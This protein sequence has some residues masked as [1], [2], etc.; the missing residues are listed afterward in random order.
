MQSE[1][2]VWQAIEQIKDAYS[3]LEG[4]MLES[5]SIYTQTFDESLSYPF[6][7]INSHIANLILPTFVSRETIP[8]EYIDNGKQILLFSGGKISTAIA[9]MY[10][11]KEENVLLWYFDNGYAD[12]NKIKPNRDNAIK[13]A[14]LLGMDIVISK[15]YY[16]TS[17]P[18][19]MM[20][21]IAEALEFI[22]EERMSPKIITG[23]FYGASVNNNPFELLG[24]SR[25]FIASE[26]DFFRKFIPEFDVSMPI[27]SYSIAWDELM[28]RREVLPYII[29]EDEVDRLTSYIIYADFDIIDSDKDKY[30]KYFNR[31][32]NIYNQETGVKHSDEEVWKRYFFYN[33]SYYSKYF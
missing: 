10:K 31:L 6:H 28:R 11:R 25:E 8:F 4:F 24:Y 9:S 12:P 32:K 19:F 20:K 14:K 3:Y 18:L 30:L 1:I 5:E 21:L 15:S 33:M 23:L 2:D 26:I 13:I 17:V 22:L 27:P 7:I 16:H 29:C